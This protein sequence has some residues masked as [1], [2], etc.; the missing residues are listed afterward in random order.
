MT[1][2]IFFWYFQSRTRRHLSEYNHVEAECPFIDLNGLLERIEDLVVDVCDRIMK[3]S[4]DLLLDVNPV[5]FTLDNTDDSNFI[6]WVFVFIVRFKIILFFLQFPNIIELDIC[7]G[8]S[9]QR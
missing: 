8:S 6:L 9:F 1:S 2:S 3:K 4:G 5:S 7:G